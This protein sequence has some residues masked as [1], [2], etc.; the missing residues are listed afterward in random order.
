MIDRFKETTFSEVFDLLPLSNTII[1]N[2]LSQNIIF[3]ESIYA[4]N[5]C[6]VFIQYEHNVNDFS[7]ILKKIRTENFFESKIKD[8]C[9][10]YIPIVKKEIHCSK[11]SFPV[12]NITDDFNELK[13]KISDGKYVVFNHKKGEFLKDKTL[14]EGNFHGFSNGII[15]EE[16]SNKVIYWTI[17]W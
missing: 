9:N 3:P 4:S 15:L 1:R 14:L 7:K 12:P 5:Y 6:G 11:Q 8:T 10:V 17:V 13:D 16:S 2:S